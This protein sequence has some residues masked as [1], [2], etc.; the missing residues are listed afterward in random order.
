MEGKGG[1]FP[2][3]SSILGAFHEVLNMVTDLATHMRPLMETLF[4]SVTD[5]RQLPSTLKLKLVCNLADMVVSAFAHVGDM[6]V[7]LL[8]PLAS[9]RV[10]AAVFLHMLRH[11]FPLMSLSYPL[12]I[13]DDRGAVPGER[14][15]VNCNPFRP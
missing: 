2:L 9:T 15:A 12:A 3:T 14:Y 11:H 6:I 10:D 4:S 1:R 8:E 5:G 13:V 7:E